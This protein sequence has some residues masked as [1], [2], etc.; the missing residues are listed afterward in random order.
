MSFLRRFKRI[1]AEKQKFF[2]GE[3]MECSVCGRIE[4]SDP[5]KSSQ[6]TAIQIPDTPIVKYFCPTCF[7]N[8]RLKK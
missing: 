4:K 7:G 1:H 2:M 5:K 3:D 6:W 8:G